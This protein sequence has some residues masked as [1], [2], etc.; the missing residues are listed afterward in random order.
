MD[1]KDEQE[2]K[3]WKEKNLNYIETYGVDIYKKGKQ[4]KNTEKIINAIN[5]FVKVIL[6]IFCILI[7]IGTGT[8]LVYRWNIIYDSIHIDP[9]ETLEGMYRI[10]VVEISKNID[11]N[12]N[13][14]Y[15]F[16]LKDNSEIKFNVLVEWASMNEDYA[17]NCQKY[18]FE[19]WENQNKNLLQTSVTYYKDVILKYEQYIQITD[20]AEIENSVKL[21]Y[22]LVKSAENKFSPDW[23]LYLKVGENSRIYPFA[24]YNINLEKS[25]NIAKS[26]YENLVK[27]P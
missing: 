17:D 24:Y 1:K 13:G 23:E 7:I 10:K 16:E 2:L 8:L 5:K 3:E 6:I 4:K 22:D 21:L 18:Y 14:S 19:H 11:S 20:E 27:N 25:I 26:E 15:I 9:K 12:Q